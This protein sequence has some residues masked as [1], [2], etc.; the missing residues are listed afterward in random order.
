MKILVLGSNGFI[1]KNIVEYYQNSENIEILDPKRAELDLCNTKSVEEYLKNNKPDFV[2]HSAVN[3]QSLEQ[4]L[5]MYFNVQRCN[6][7]FGKLITIGSGA[8]YDMKNYIPMM[9]E[10]Y[11]ETYIPSDTYGLSK[12]IASRDIELLNSNSVNL[13]VLGIFGKYEDYT[14]RFISNNICRAIC[15]YDITMFQNMKFDYLYVKDFLRILDIFIDK[16]T[17]YKNYNI[18]TSQPVEF[19][20]LA[21]LIHDTHGNSNT[22]IIV[23]QE[24]MKPEYSA[25]N[26]RFLNEFG[27]FE[28]TSFET[29]INE[30]YQWYKNEIDLSSYCQELKEKE[31]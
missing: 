2:I 27:P 3:I 4:N 17:K 1:G 12:Y 22:K 7:Y 28:F 24:G 18:C 14:R 10:E 25:D 6:E 16:E 29:S 23:K 8:E 19:N 31:A 9:K 30:L 26:S 15:G 21:Q 5:Q 11:F 20:R 13:R